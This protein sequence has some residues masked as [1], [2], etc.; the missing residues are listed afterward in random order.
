[1]LYKVLDDRRKW[2]ETLFFVFLTFPMQINFV[3]QHS[4]IAML[5]EPEVHWKMKQISSQIIWFQFFYSGSH[6]ACEHGRRKDFSMRTNNV[7]DYARSWRK[8]F[9]QRGLTMVYFYCTNLKLREKRFS[10]KTLIRKYQIS[11]SRWGLVHP[12]P[13]FRRSCP[14]DFIM[15]I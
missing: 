1:M 15:H 14:C 3:I 11:K 12:F 8:T 4:N 13:L 5:E 6:T 10:T 2:F 9:F 7:L